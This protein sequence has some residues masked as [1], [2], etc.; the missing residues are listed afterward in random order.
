MVTCGHSMVTC[1]Q[2]MVDSWSIH[3]SLWLSVVNAWSAFGHLWSL[4]DQLFVNLWS[5]SGQSVVHLW[6]A[7]GPSLGN[8]WT[9]AVWHQKTLA[10]LLREI[11]LSWHVPI[12][13]SVSQASCVRCRMTSSLA[14]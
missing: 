7:Y 12:N 5:I 1:S 8:L 3:D 9:E 10:C 14:T 13:G 4:N 2:S 11:L 6:S